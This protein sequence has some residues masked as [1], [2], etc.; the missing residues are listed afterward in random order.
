MQK[1]FIQKCETAKP[2]SIIIYIPLQN[3]SWANLHPRASLFDIYSNVP[4]TI[5]NMTEA[6]ELLEAK[7][8]E[9][10]TVLDVLKG[11][12]KILLEKA[13]EAVTYNLE[14]D[15]CYSTEEEKAELEFF[16]SDEYKSNTLDHYSNDDLIEIILNRPTCHLSSESI[17]THLIL[18]TV[19]F[20]PMGN[21]IFCRDHQIITSKGVIIGNLNCHQRKREVDLIRWFY[22]LLKVPLIGEIKGENKLEGGDFM[23]IKEDISLLGIGMRTNFGAASY[24]M[25]NDLLGTKIFGLVVDEN[26][27]NQHRMHLDTIFNILSPEE[28]ILLDMNTV[29]PK[30]IRDGKEVDIRRTVH[31]YERKEVKKEYG[32]YE[33]VKKIDFEEF[34]ISEGFKIIKVTHEQQSDFMINF[35]NIG[36]GEVISPNKD[37]QSFLEKNGSKT[38]ACFVEFKEVTKMYGAFHCATQAIRY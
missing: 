19:E 33:L 21:M 15:L 12:R 27:F 17:N 28:V 11:D 4:Q 36:D 20:Q 8:I 3:F 25:E 24:L 23:I 10:L 16:L 6:K 1:L 13:K 9:V 22:E 7:G 14:S 32:N 26:D 2:N 29:K 34:L 35:L 31:I 5:I 38:K 37:M 18:K 30:K